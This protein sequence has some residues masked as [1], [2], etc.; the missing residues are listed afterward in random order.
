[1]TNKIIAIQGNHPS[2]LNPKTDTTIF[3]A[4]EIQNK[5]YKLFYF[6]PKN[7][8]IINKKVV[9]K[10]SFV[11]FSY[12]N[13]NFYKIIKNQKLDLIKCKF[14]LIRQD[15][16]FNLEYISTT[17]ILENIKNKVKII[18]DPTSI[19]NISEKLYSAKFLKFM[20]PTIFTQNISEIKNFFKRYKR[21]IIKPIHS[22]GG[23]DIYLL[24][25]FKFNLIN[26]FIRK[27]DHIMCQK[28]LPD[29]RKG[30]K[31]VFIINGKLRGAISRIPKKN[32]F[33]S[34]MS[35]GAKP[36]ITKLTKKET[37]IS[38]YIAKDLRQKKI[39]FAGIDFIGQKLNGDINVT[40]PTGLKTFYDLSNINLAKTFWK[41]LKA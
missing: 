40:S 38:N 1:M 20:P 32:S 11:K 34:N 14:I 4:N 16:P 23:N 25:K 21:V 5:N 26:K 35:K 24:D 6:T 30:D 18:N 10:G 8:S 41:D 13:K 19:R 3:L 31:R 17:F 37:K 28:F 29:I 12:T 39:F 9:A 15:P 27:Y 33:L 2:Q 7:L 36:I 22:F